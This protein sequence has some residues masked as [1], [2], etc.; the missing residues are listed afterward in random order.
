MTCCGN[1]AKSTFVGVV[2]SYALIV[3]AAYYSCHYFSG[4]GA[5]LQLGAM[6]GTIMFTNVWMRILPPQRRM[7][8]AL[9]A[10]TAPNLEEAARAKQRSKHNTFIVIP[11]VFIM[12]SNHYPITRTAARIIGLFCR[13]SCWWVGRRRRL[14]AGHEALASR[15]MTNALA[16]AIAR[17]RR[18]CYHSLRIPSCN[19]S[20]LPSKTFCASR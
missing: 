18:P 7:V 3:V 8:A 15:R 6:F 1:S 10:G 5:Y 9:K 19:Q 2:I 11:V 17:A 20:C 4:R 13:S 16:I 12:I 14:F